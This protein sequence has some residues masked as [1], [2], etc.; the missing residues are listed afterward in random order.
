MVDQAKTRLY[1]CR[2]HIEFDET[3]QYQTIE[4]NWSRSSAAFPVLAAFFARRDTTL[5]YFLDLT[6]DLV[7]GNLDDV[8][9]CCVLR[10]SFT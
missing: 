4:N 8:P 5:V 2:L 10:S 7:F 6:L 1:I 9:V 3:Q